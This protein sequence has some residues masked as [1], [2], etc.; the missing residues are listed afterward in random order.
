MSRLLL[1]LTILPFMIACK[2]DETKKL[3]DIEQIQFENF[4]PEEFYQSHNILNSAKVNVDSLNVYNKEVLTGAFQIDAFDIDPK[5]YVFYPDY[6]YYSQR[7]ET[8]DHLTE[9]ETKEERAFGGIPVPEIAFFR[10]IKFNYGHFIQD[11]KTK[12]I[13]G[14]IFST[15]LHSEPNYYQKTMDLV[16]K[17]LGKPQYTYN[18]FSDDEGGAVHYPLVYDVWI[19]DG[20]MLQFNK[21]IRDEGDKKYECITLLILNENLIDTFDSSQNLRFTIFKDFFDPDRSRRHMLEGTL[22]KR[23]GKSDLEKAAEMMR[24]HL[25]STKKS[26]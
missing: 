19:R 2:K 13:V 3:T 24:K 17:E 6:T 8:F 26:R 25:D 11:K 20:E 12:K 16:R 15:I 21:D 9:K 10:N 1:L 18:G 14:T 23:F 4:S 22:M 7:G 5:N